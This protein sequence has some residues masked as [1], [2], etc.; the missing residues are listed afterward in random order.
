M[1]FSIVTNWKIGY[2]VKQFLRMS[3][4]TVLQYWSNEFDHFFE[5]LAFEISKNLDLISQQ[6]Y[7]NTFV[8]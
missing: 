5:R 8:I 7:A 6:N 4:F 2:K 3:F 1:Y